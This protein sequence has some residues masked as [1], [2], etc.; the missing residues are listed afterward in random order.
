MKIISVRPVADRGSGRFRDVAIFDAEIVDGL[1][2]VGLK[3]A[4]T[5]EGRRFVFGPEAH[6]QRFIKF[7]GEYPRQLADA[8]WC[9][10][11]GGVAHDRT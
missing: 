3:L 4:V 8:A 11:G 9:A 2:I 7:G 10:L 6:G 5:N 1:V